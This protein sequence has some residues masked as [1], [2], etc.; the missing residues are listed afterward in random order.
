MPIPLVPANYFGKGED[1]ILSDDKPNEIKEFDD[2]YKEWAEAHPEDPTG[3]IALAEFRKRNRITPEEEITSSSSS[4]E[5]E[6]QGSA[7]IHLEL[8]ETSIEKLK[9][10]ARFRRRRPRDIINGWIEQF[11]KL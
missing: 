7:K 9:N 1:F 3:E 6:F 5:P 4:V 2:K 10:Y 8:P 11:C